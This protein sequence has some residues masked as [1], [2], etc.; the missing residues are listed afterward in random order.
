MVCTSGEVMIT[1]GHIR[2]AGGAILAT[3]LLSV[4]MS[5]GAQEEVATEA[6]SQQTMEEIVVVAN[7][8]GDPVEIDAQYQERLRAR[9]IDEY[10]RLQ[11]AQEEEQ[12]RKSL[13]TAIREPSSRISWGY[14]AQAESRMRREMELTDLPTDTLKPA[15][16][17]SVSF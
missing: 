16:V 6:A 10:M 17:I 15:T 4:W 11:S 7:K 8:G 2:V 5:A 13:P 9:I 14:D 3:A 1:S 12:W